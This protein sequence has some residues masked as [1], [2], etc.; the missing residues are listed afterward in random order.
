MRAGLG[1]DRQPVRLGRAD[2]GQRRRAGQVHDVGPA[3]GPPGLPEQQGDGPLLGLGRPGGQEVRVPPAA[4]GGGRLDHARVLGVRDEQAAEA[5]DLGHG[6]AELRLV[7]RGELVHARGE[8]E[9]L[10]AR[11]ARLVQ[12]PQVGDVA[13]HRPAPERDVHRKLAGRGGL[14]GA[15]RGHGH[16]RRDAVQRH[17][18]D[19]GHPARG[20][21]R[22]G[23]REPFPL[24]APGLVH[25]HVAVHQPGQQHLVAGQGDRAGRRFRVTGQAGDEAVADEHGRSPLAVRR[26]DPAAPDRRHLTHRTPRHYRGAFWLYRAQNA[27]R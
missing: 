9:A 12:G 7:Q 11:H 4:G 13:R 24:G 15:Q 20:G 26:D 6:R 2:G 27:P 8:Q 19:R 23:G 21:G 17:V 3:P 14:L 18:H 5:G 10:E 25:V 1:G 22:G 16:G